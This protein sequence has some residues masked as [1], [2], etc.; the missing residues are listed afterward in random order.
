MAIRPTL[1]AAFLCVV[2]A[3]ASG[4]RAPL[5]I[6]D[7]DP[8]I[9]R[10]SFQVAD[11]FEVKLLAA[12][13]MITKPIQM[14]FDPRGRLWIAGSEVYPRGEPGRKANDKLFILEDKDGD[15]RSDPTTVFTGGF[16]IPTGI[17][18]SD[19]GAYVANRTELLHF[20]DS[21]GDDKADGRR[22][23]L[24]G[25]GTEDTRHI[26]RTLRWGPEGRLLF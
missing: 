24:S 4:Q 15:G 25:F 3:L 2:P 10:Q 17:E 18:P 19:G 16:L 21:D 22:T 23:A 14:N 1:L 6:P 13:Q 20:Q 7:P 5:Q 8:E 12:N 26:L 9:K 11:G